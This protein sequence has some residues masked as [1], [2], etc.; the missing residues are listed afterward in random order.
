MRAFVIKGRNT[1]KH[2]GISGGYSREGG[3]WEGVG[4]YTCANILSWFCS[5]LIRGREIEER[6]SKLHL[7]SS[8][9]LGLD[10]VRD[11]V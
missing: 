4:R 8:S 10:A 11:T 5:G 3:S 7:A 2:D 1:R 6:V 9:R